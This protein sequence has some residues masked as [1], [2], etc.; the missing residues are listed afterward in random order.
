[1]SA[2]SAYLV[3]IVAEL[4]GS[5]VV[6]FTIGYALKKI[7]K[8]LL[9]VAGVFATVLGLVLAWLENQGILTI[10]VDYGK[11]DT[12][13]QTSLSWALS[14]VSN[15]AAVAAQGLAI[16]GGFAVGITLGFNKG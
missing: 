3:T 15:F 5:G 16:S 6:G 10:T 13:V 1:M 8:L 2:V 14:Q 7:L 4:G 12:L 11:L 9:V